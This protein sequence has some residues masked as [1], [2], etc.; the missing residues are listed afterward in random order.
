MTSI[1]TKDIIRHKFSEEDKIIQ[2]AILILK[3]RLRPIGAR[4][5]DIETTNNY[6]ILKLASEEREIFGCLFLSSAGCLILDEVLFKGSLRDCQ[7]SPREVV[8][9]A[10]LCNADSVI[11]YH[12]HP[13]GNCDPSQNDKNI[14]KILAKA[15]VTID[16]KL[17]DHVIVAGLN[18]YSFIKNSLI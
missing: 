14:T 9:A 7:V 3:T 13:S 8:K 16:V 12:N 18:T 4:F 11:L 15:L 1:L 2:Q 6:L 5:G 10:L 17:H